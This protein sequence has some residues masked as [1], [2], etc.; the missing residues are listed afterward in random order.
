MEVFTY[1]YKCK[2]WYGHVTGTRNLY[3]EDSTP[4]QTAALQDAKA[5]SGSE[6]CD[7]QLMQKFRI[8]VTDVEMFPGMACQPLHCFN[9]S[10]P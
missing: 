9:E 6:T 3:V 2:R 4:P 8:V 7:V 10:V 5:Y 1:R